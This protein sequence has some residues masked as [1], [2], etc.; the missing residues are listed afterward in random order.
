MWTVSSDHIDL[1]LR[2]AEPGLT[3]PCTLPLHQAMPKLT[4]EPDDVQQEA[5]PY[6]DDQPMIVDDPA[7]E[8]DGGASQWED[9]PANEV[10]IQSAMLQVARS[11]Y[12]VY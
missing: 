7:S 3:R 6:H 11:P 9:L 8:D 12:V 5:G 10:F 1:S 4:P 2:R